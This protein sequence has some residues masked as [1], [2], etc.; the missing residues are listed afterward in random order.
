MTSASRAARPGTWATCGCGEPVRPRPR[1]AHMNLLGGIMS[2][3]EGVMAPRT[4]AVLNRVI[5]ATEHPDVSDRELLRRFAAGAQAAFTAIVRRHG[6]MVLGFCRR[7]LQ[8]AQDAEDA[9]QA[10]F[11]VLAR[12]AASG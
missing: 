1:S 6:A 7:M 12:K 4:A 9:C 11:V 2:G 3:R 8:N 5:W 10:T